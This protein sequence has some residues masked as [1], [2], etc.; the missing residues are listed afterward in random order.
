MEP[1]LVVP[2]HPRIAQTSYSGDLISHGGYRTQ[3]GYGP[4]A[5]FL[6]SHGGQT[7]EFFSQNNQNYSHRNPEQIP[8]ELTA[9]GGLQRIATNVAFLLEGMTGINGST[10]EAILKP[11]QKVSILL[12]L[13]L[14]RVTKA[15]TKRSPDEHNSFQDAWDEVVGNP[16]SA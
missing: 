9:L 11:L 6:G 14:S 2:S 5:A 10:L 12:A 7:P 15:V 8:H 1:L 13:T 16:I 3:T 4:Q